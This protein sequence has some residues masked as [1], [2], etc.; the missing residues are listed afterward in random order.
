MT[1]QSPWVIAIDVE[2]G[3]RQ[4]V[5]GSPDEWSGF[6][7]C[8]D[9]FAKWRQRVLERSSDA[10]RLTW[11]FRVD[12][13][14]NSWGSID[15][16]LNQYRRCIADL[17]E[18]GDE[19]G[20]HF[21][22]YTSA[23]SAGVWAQ[24]YAYDESIDQSLK[25]AVKAYG[26][27]M[28]KRP[29]YFR[30]GDHWLSDAVVSRL[31]ALGIE[32]D[33]TV[34]PGRPPKDAEP[35]DVGVFPDYRG[36]PRTPY[37]PSQRDFLRR[38]NSDARNIW[39]MPVTTSCFNHPGEWHV[40]DGGSHRTE[41]LH[42]GFDSQFVQPF[43]DK[44]LRSRQG[45]IVSVMR[46]GDVDWSPWLLPNLNYLFDHRDVA[47]VVFEPPAAALE[48]YLKRPPSLLSRLAVL[49]QA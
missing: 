49:N 6:E 46:T 42:L 16:A 3:P 34:E 32:Y 10:L 35:P 22:A 39:M 44:M 28:D 2:P 38:G 37:H 18:L 26:E 48:R 14:V 4:N 21:H 23:D 9:F 40:S 13:Q 7:L 11:F 8:V 12:L 15:W 41:T 25:S 36:A 1:S 45:I 19:F 24:K 30:F 33:L 27:A 17:A 29:R 31:E 5:R 20:L 43:V 47:K